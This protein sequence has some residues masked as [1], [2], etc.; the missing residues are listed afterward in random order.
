MIIFAGMETKYNLESVADY[1]RFFGVDVMHPLVSI[2]DFADYGPYPGGLIQTNLYCVMY[3]ELECGE[4][5]YGRSRY[6]YQAGTLLFVSPGQ[7]IGIGGR[8]MDTPLYKGQILLIHPDFMYGTPLA[9]LIG[10]YSFFSYDSN[11]ALHMSDKEKSI[12]LGCFRDIKAE[13]ELCIDKHTKKIVCSRIE[14]M[15]DHCERFYERQFITREVY[16]HSVISR[17]DSYLRDYFD[18]DRQSECGIPTVQSCASEMCL[19]ANYFSDLIKRETGKTAQEYIQSHVIELAKILLSEKDKNI[20]AIAYELGFRYP[21][22][23]TRVF[24]KMTGVTPQEYR[25]VSN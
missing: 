11:E 6:D 13:L 19:S 2:A 10:G 24:K 14:T 8:D 9:R 23:L 25:T 18:N 5:K 4:M 7:V 15:L 20:T 17:L 1:C 3:K 21:H 16:N 22:H 12:I